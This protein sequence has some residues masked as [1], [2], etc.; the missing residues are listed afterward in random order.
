MASKSVLREIKTNETV[1]DSA[2]K[3]ELPKPYEWNI[4][5]ESVFVFLYIHAISFYGLLHILR[6]SKWTIMWYFVI[7]VLSIIGTT[8]GSHRLWAHRA[9][10]A[11]WPLRV[12][13][14]IFQTLAY[15]HHIVQWSQEHRLHHKFTDTDADPYNARRG[16]FFSHMGWLVITKHPEVTRKMTLLDFSDLK[17]DF[18]VAFQEKYYFYLMT[19]FFIV[20]VMVP[21]LMWNESLWYSFVGN[22]TRYCITLHGTWLVNSVAHM[23]GMKPYDKSITPVEN[24]IIAFVTTGEGWHNYHH[25]FPWDYK[26]SELGNY[27]M[28]ITTAFIDFFA[29]IGWAYDLK[30]ASPDMVKNR[31]LRNNKDTNDTKNSNCFE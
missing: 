8:A 15:G 25:V 5:W 4:I 14:M 9:Y 24:A 7:Y 20:P 1:I 11:K 30:I 17:R 28:N 29:L 26:A 22:V 3:K 13:L 6:M 2:P 18:V 23:W 19:V 10:K 21:W 12:I 31:I 16:F 27:S